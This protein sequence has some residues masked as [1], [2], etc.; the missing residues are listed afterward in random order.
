L[1]SGVAARTARA[2]APMIAMSFRHTAIFIV[3]GS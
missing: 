1:K 2:I 3:G